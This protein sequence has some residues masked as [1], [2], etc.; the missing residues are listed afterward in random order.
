M[1]RSVVGKDG[2]TGD[3]HG[4][5]GLGD[6]A[7]SSGHIYRSGTR[8]RKHDVLGIVGADRS[9][10]GEAHIDGGGGNRTGGTHGDGGAAAGIAAGTAHR[11]RNLKAR[12][13]R[14]G[15]ACCHIGTG[16][17]E[18]GWVGGRAEGGAHGGERAQGGDGRR[19]AGR[20]RV[21]SES[22][23]A[24]E[25]GAGD[26]AIRARG[27]VGSRGLLRRAEKQSVHGLRIGEIH[28]AAIDDEL[29]GIR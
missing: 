24:S 22:S 23:C 14:D 20:T 17:R 11:L 29:A 3:R 25:V 27:A 7:G 13:W 8:A 19:A 15:D 6:G 21:H 12:R 1:G 28:L 26:R 16:D 18:G 2:D 5:G 10:V 4:R 9:G